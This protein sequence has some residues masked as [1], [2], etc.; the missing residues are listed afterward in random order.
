MVFALFRLLIF[1]TDLRVLPLLFYFE[2]WS[3]KFSVSHSKQAYESVTSAKLGLS[4][5]KGE[6]FV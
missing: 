1:P 5:R 4:A 3:K 6:V 2:Q